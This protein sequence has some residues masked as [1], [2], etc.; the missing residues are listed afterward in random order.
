[1]KPRL[2]HF[3][4]ECDALRA[5]SGNNLTVP[6]LRRLYGKL[7]R[8]TLV[9]ESLIHVKTY[10]PQS[11]RTPRRKTAPVLTAAQKEIVLGGAK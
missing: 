6:E 7:Y 9:V 8:A 1:M 11:S 5:G 2:Q 10:Y 4:N 3:L